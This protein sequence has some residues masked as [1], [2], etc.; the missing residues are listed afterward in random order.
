MAENGVLLNYLY[1]NTHHLPLV[2]DITGY[3]ALE[4]SKYSNGNMR[5][6]PKMNICAS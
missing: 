1:S 3:L 5:E 6:A 4:C 2:T